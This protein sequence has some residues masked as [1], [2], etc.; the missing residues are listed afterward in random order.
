MRGAP[1]DALRTHRHGLEVG[2]EAQERLAELAEDQLE[3]ADL[4]P[5]GHHLPMVLG[6]LV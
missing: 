2:W 6:L 5:G 1:G 4:A 3:L